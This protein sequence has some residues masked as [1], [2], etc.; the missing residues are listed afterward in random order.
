MTTID[1]PSGLQIKWKGI[2]SESGKA[3]KMSLAEAG[4]NYEKACQLYQQH[5]FMEAKSILA[6]LIIHNVLE[7]RYYFAAAA[8][9][10]GEK[11][12]KTAIQLYT[13]CSMLVPDNPFPVFYS[14][15]CHLQLGDRGEALEGFRKV[16]G[17][18]ATSPEL[19]AL[20]DKANAMMELLRPAKT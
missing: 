20:R 2:S 6:L 18:P 17:M 5:R 4:R 1:F 11:N 7:T 16:A 19:L 14:A 15:E 10:Q 12:F 8:C 13:T 9:L 3:A